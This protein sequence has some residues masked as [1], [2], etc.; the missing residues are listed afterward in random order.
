VQNKFVVVC[1][2][3][4]CDDT[5]KLQK[6]GHQITFPNYLASQNIYNQQAWKM[7]QHS[8]HITYAPRQTQKTLAKLYIGT[9]YFSLWYF[10]IFLFFFLIYWYCLYEKIQSN[11]CVCFALSKT[12]NK[13][14]ENLCEN[15]TPK[16]HRWVMT[17]KM[18]FLLGLWSYFSCFIN[19]YCTDVRKKNN[20]LVKYL[21]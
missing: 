16:L 12:I 4:M 8:S 18:Y 5:V 21:H 11:L 3:Q 20:I 13:T 14:M 9:W 10:D 15:T 6:L 2:F 1:V 7:I 19:F 17:N